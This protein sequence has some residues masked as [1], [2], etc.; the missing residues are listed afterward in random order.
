PTTPVWQYLYKSGP[1]F[2]AQIAEVRAALRSLGKMP[3]A[4]L[5]RL[6]SET[7]DTCSHRVDAW[8]TSLATRRLQT[9]MRP[10]QATGLHLG[11]YGWLERVVPT[12]RNRFSSLFVGPQLV[13]VP[14][15]GGGYIHA[16]SAA[17]ASTA[18]VLRNA[19][20][21]RGGSS[22]VYAIDLSS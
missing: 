5:D 9:E 4:E 11:A 14:K 8:V 22:T 2:S 20:M 1:T 18:A 15:Q 12:A 13:F 6:V 17:M 21:T 3:T 7:L 16:P 10:A 19:Y